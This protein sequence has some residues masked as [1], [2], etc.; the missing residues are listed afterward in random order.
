MALREASESAAQAL[1]RLQD[2]HARL[3]E[4]SAPF[5]YVPKPSLSARRLMSN[6]G[7]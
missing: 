5:R 6:T 2:E 1:A 7:I 3:V 4:Q